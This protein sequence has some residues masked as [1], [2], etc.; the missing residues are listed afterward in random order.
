LAPGV[1]YDSGRS[2][3]AGALAVEQVAG[4]D[5]VQQEAVAGVA[6]AVTKWVDCPGTV[7]AGAAGQFSITQ[8]KNGQ[9]G[10]L[11]S[12]ALC[13]DLTFSRRIR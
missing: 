1:V 12:A 6:L 8:E 7:G 9:S 11:P 13:I 2:Y 4:I 3:L 10:E 5:A